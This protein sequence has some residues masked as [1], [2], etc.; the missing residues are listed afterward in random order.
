MNLELVNAA[1][2][3]VITVVFNGDK[4]LER[5]IQSVINQDYP[6]L[7]Y[8]IVDGGSTDGTIDIIRRYQNKID[9]WHS[10]K[11]YGIYDA[12]NRGLDHASGA[13]VIFMN[14]G[15][16]FYNQKTVSE[17]FSEV[18]WKCVVIY[19]GVQILYPGFSRIESP[20]NPKHLWKG[21]QF[22]H[23]S[24]FIDREYHQAHRYNIS[25]KIAADLEFFYNAFTDGAKFAKTT[26]VISSVI[27]GGVSETHRVATILSS[28]DAICGQNFKPF[29]RL[30][31]YLKAIYSI[32]KVMVK[33]LLPN[34]L[35]KRIILLKK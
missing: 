35:V 19:G 4:Y 33:K 6:N 28:M 29:I 20:G 23:Q 30:Y 9:Y 31:F 34:S 32:I 14:A 25:N 2:I 12:M 8:V 1:K 7:E 27:T 22:S 18:N 16:T 11:D 13:W 3:T 10:K 17:V 5:T 24:T 15:D 21:M 26:K